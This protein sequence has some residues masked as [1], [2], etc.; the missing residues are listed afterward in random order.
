M[1]KENKDHENDAHKKHL[2]HIEE[3]NQENEE[4]EREFPADDTFSEDGAIEFPS[5]RENSTEELNPN[6]QTAMT[7]ET[8]TDQ[9]DLDYDGFTD[10]ERYSAEEAGEAGGFTSAD[11]DAALEERIANDQNRQGGD[12][13]LKSTNEPL[14]RPEKDGEETENL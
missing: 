1:D 7:T 11:N 6:D 5:E 3:T 9:A 10:E 14:G 13:N 8:G 12:V 2:R 4:I